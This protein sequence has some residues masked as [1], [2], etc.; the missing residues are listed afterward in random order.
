MRR[1]EQ[2]SILTNQR[3]CAV[4]QNRL[5]FGGERPADQHKIIICRATVVAANEL[6]V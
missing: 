4:W 5:A 2:R 1:L 3:L 6:T